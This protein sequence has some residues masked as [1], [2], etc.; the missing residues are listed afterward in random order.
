SDESTLLNLPEISEIPFGIGNGSTVKAKKITCEFT[1]LN[2]TDQAFKGFSTASGKKVNV[3]EEAL[4]KVQNLFEECNGAS[5]FNLIESSEIVPDG[6]NMSVTTLSKSMD[7]NSTDLAFKEFSTA[8]VKNAHVSDDKLKRV[9]KMFEECV[10]RAQ[11]ENSF[12]NSDRATIV[13]NKSQEVKTPNTFSRVPIFGGFLTASG[14]NVTVTEEALNKAQ[15]LLE[16]C[17]DTTP[18]FELSEC[19]SDRKIRTASTK[20]LPTNKNSQLQEESSFTASKKTIITS[21]HNVST[22]RESAKEVDSYV[23]TPVRSRVERAV[24]SKRTFDS[25][26]PAKKFRKDD[27]FS[28][29][30][31]EQPSCRTTAYATPPPPAARRPWPRATGAAQKL[32]SEEVAADVR[33]CRRR[34]RPATASSGRGSSPAGARRAG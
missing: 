32:L 11:F 1:G 14:K 21:D 3:S 2:S 22:K 16:E 5:P 9:P 27:S 17:A 26:Q 4:K 13:A 18:S 24:C 33:R 12:A 30:A 8:S 25:S 31:G 29:T 23:E 19:S 15:K 10:D 34:S 20:T 7:H 28:G 6:H